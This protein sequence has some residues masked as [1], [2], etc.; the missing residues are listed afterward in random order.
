LLVDAYRGPLTC[1]QA[2][3]GI[4]AARANAQ[5]LL[6]EAKLLARA[7]RWAR[8]AALAILAIEEVGKVPIIRMLLLAGSDNE[9]ADTWRDFVR[10]TS[11]NGSPHLSVGSRTVIPPQQR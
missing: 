10:H 4:T 9:L 2:A 3:A 1:G 6:D 11:K 7:K 5:E 8:A